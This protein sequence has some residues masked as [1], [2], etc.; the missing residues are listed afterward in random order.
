MKVLV[1]YLFP[2]IS[3]L[4]DLDGQGALAFDRLPSAFRALGAT[5]SHEEIA[6]IANL[7]L[8][9]LDATMNFTQFLTIMQAY[10]DRMDVHN[11]AESIQVLSSLED[12]AL[13]LDELVQV[14]RS[15]GE[16]FSDDEVLEI[17]REYG[18][19]DGTISSDSLIPI[20]RV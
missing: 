16:T 13:T 7:V 17:M 8:P 19:G 3:W 20:I 9:D 1:F 12:R 6:E 14:L 5:P 15:L 2:F 4:L 18:N 10:V 11:N